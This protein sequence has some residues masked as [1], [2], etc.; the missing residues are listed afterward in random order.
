MT[1]DE[2]TNAVS[3]ITLQFEKCIQQAEQ[4]SARL[5]RMSQE[6][7][8]HMTLWDSC[9]WLCVLACVVLSIFFGWR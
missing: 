8:P 6:T 7:S 9:F 5:H 2:S 4:T 3:G 1:T